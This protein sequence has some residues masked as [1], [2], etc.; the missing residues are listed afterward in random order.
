[1][2]VDLR[3]YVPPFIESKECEFQPFMITSLPGHVGDA[4]DD[5]DIGDDPGNGGKS[6]SFWDDDSYSSNVKKKR[7]E[8]KFWEFTPWMDYLW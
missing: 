7:K 3:K 6:N 1:M 2:K 5:G 4:G 8:P